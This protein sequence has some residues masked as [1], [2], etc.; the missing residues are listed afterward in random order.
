MKI[1]IAPDKFKGSLSA[2][3]VCAAICN[4]LKKSDAALQI[5]TLPLAD[6]GEGTAQLLTE[7]TQGTWKTCV[8]HDPLFRKIEAGYGISGDGTIAFIEMASASGLQLLTA[9]ERNPLRTTTLGT[10][11][12]IAD[13]L[14]FDVNKIVVAIGGS[15]TNDAGIG[16]AAALGYRFYDQHKQELIPIGANLEYLHG[17]DTPA[18][19]PR[20]RTTEF[21]VLC[22]VT[23]PLYGV[24]G[25]AFV[26]APQKGATPTDVEHLDRGLQN[27]SQVVRDQFQISTDFAGAGAAGGLGAGAKVF[28]NAALTRGIDYLIAQLHVEA[29]IRKADLV[30]TGEGKL[31]TQTLQGKVV[32]GVTALAVQHH[33]PVVVITGKNELSEA[34]WKPIGINKVISLVNESTLVHEAMTQTQTLLEQRIIENRAYFLSNK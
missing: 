28:L 23:N 31:D 8:V 34:Q 16:M 2:T 30:I 32:A 22:D 11:E 3:E 29:A 5:Q 7:Q 18:L 1:L 6:G 20:L 10:G 12:L 33:K 24:H 27:F 17:V 13:A 15:A 25:A 21:C 9:E 26:F 4:A 19:H 14:N